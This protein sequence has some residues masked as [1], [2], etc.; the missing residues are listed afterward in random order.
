[1]ARDSSVDAIRV[2]LLVVVFLQHAVMVGVSVGTSGPVVQNALAAQEWVAPVSWVIQIMPL[3]FIVGGFSSFRHWRSM[4]ARGGTAV[5][6]VR[7]RL[8]RLVRPSIVLVAV[9]GVSLVAL[10]LSG[11]PPEIVAAAGFWTGQPLWFLGVYLGTSALVPLMVRAHD[12][13]RVLT[14]IGLLAGVVAVD[15]IR[16]ATGV[17][18]VGFLNL[19][20]VWLLV[21]QLGF[22]LADGAVDASS[23]FALWGIAVGSLALLAVLTVVGPYPVDMLVNLNPPSVCLVVLGVAQ[24]A[25]FQLA[26]PRIRAWASRPVPARVISAIGE[27]AMT[28]YLWHMP[29]LIGLAGLSLILSLRLGVNL[30]LPL[31]SEWWLTRPLWLLGAAVV[32][33]LVTLT[34]GPL[35]AVASPRAPR[36]SSSSGGGPRRRST[37]CARS[38][39]SSCCWSP[40]S[41]CCGYRS[42]SSCSPSRC[43]AA[44]RPGQAWRD[45]DARRCGANGA[46]LTRVSAGAGRG[47]GSGPCPS[48][49]AA[50]SS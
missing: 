33:A 8:E 1:M 13:A 37:S 27:R 49:S 30:P 15:V 44:R 43:G 2:V 48:G 39:P 19:V 35:R 45:A 20:L 11:V 38:A 21:Q 18:A 31:S 47:L 16:L 5:D 25:L 26:R 14:P 4:Q 12:R 24:V 36:Q 6:Y 34:V 23:R 10:S 9:I 29:V 3:F 40:A 41:A 32:V 50:R 42:R 17:Q 28:V 22:H 7:A 46:R